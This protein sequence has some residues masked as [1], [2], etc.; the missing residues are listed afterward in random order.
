MAGSG[1]SGTS[2][3]G[4]E[5]SKEFLTCVGESGVGEILAGLGRRGEASMTGESSWEL[6]NVMGISE[7][8]RC[9]DRDR[10]LGGAEGTARRADRRRGAVSELGG[11]PDLDFGKRPFFLLM[12]EGPGGAFE[13]RGHQQRR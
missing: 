7:S 1:V 6:G 4:G 5:V 12:Q 2:W 10:L 8:V 11:G 3:A 13:R 9:R